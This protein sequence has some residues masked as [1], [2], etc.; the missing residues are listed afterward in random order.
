MVL[1]VSGD[2][3][4]AVGENNIIAFDRNARRG[5][6]LRFRRSGQQTGRDV[7]FQ[8]PPVV[9]S[10]NKGGNWMEVDYK[11]AEPIAIFMGGRPRE[12][13]LKWFYLVG[14]GGWSASKVASQVKFVRSYFYNKISD[15][16]VIDF[17]AYDV[18]GPGRNGQ[19]RTWSFRADAV[20]VQHSPTLVAMDGDF[21]PLRTDLNLTLK[22]YTSGDT[23]NADPEEVQDIKNLNN[24]NA[25]KSTESLI[26]YP[27]G[28]WF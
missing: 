1:V 11:H 9:T 8:F 14:F 27:G 13:Q 10:D 15:S 25:V 20:T 7:S 26:E 5:V 12:V 16:F 19:V 18:V 28:E 17:G 24:I 6:V 22:L 21:Y 23:G 4:M 3:T 2:N